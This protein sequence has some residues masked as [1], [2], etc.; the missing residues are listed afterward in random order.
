MTE[1]TMDQQMSAEIGK[2]WDEKRIDEIKKKRRINSVRLKITEGLAWI[3][4]LPV[5][6]KTYELMTGDL[7]YTWVAMAV[8]WLAMAIHSVLR[9]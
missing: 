4:C 5:W 7:R 3:A 6:A 9:K 2:I 8:A 1:A